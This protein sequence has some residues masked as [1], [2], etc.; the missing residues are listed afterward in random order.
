MLGQK[1]GD[2]ADGRA[3]KEFF[4]VKLKKAYQDKGYILYDCRIEPGFAEP[5][6]TSEEDETID[7]SVII[8][9]NKSFKL[10]KIEFNGVEPEKAQQLKNNFSLKEGDTY[11]AG[12]LKDEIKKLNDSGEFYF[13]NDG[14]DVEFRTDQTNGFLH[15]I[16]YLKKN[17]Q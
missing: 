16:I 15:L 12:K 11:A 5:T 2:I 9:E 17:K 13:I 14:A 1:T 10:S 3:F 4:F 6:T 8:D 7:I